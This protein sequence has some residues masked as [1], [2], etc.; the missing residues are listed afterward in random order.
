MGAPPGTPQG[1]SIVKGPCQACQKEMSYIFPT[2]RIFN[3]IDVS[4]LAIAHPPSRCG[5]CQAVHLPLIQGLSE[6]GVLEITWKVAKVQRGPMIIGAD[7][8][9]LKKAIAQAEFT[10]RIKKQGN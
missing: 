1:P 10:D 2:P 9:V 4:I 6:M 3:E 5:E 7:D 8:N